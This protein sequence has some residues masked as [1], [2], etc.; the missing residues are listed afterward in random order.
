M[1]G[2]T[3]WIAEHRGSAEADPAA[4]WRILSDVDGWGSWNDGIETIT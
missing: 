3:M 4:V 2:A 1:D